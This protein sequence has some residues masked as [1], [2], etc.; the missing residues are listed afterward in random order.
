MLITTAQ[1]RRLKRALTSRK[2][3][4]RSLDEVTSALHRTGV[5]TE[6]ETIGYVLNEELELEYPTLSSI[7][8][9]KKQVISIQK[10]DGN[11][12]YIVRSFTREYTDS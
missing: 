11:G 4:V 10:R 1:G 9:N 3:T 6:R 8:Y 7:F 5:F 12:D 2:N